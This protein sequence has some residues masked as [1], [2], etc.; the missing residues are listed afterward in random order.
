MKTDIEKLDDIF[1]EIKRREAVEEEVA[2]LLAK[3]EQD[4]PAL[5]ARLRLKPD[6]RTAAGVRRKKKNEARRKRRLRDRNY[7]RGKA[8][9]LKLK[10]LE[11][12]NWWLYLTTR[13]KQ[14]GVPVEMTLAEW[15]ELVK[16]NLQEGE[17]LTVKRYEANQAVSWSNIYVTASRAGKSVVVYDGAEE[18]LKANGY[19]L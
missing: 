1:R 2:R 15:D 6:G 13:W 7:K 9:E 14:D 19:C 5:L 12:N 3:K 11:D 4:E 10:V 8:M 17:A 18:L 16:P